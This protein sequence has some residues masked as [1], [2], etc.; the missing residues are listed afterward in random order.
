MNWIGGT[1]SRSRNANAKGS[2]LLKQKNHFA[3]A[4]VKLQNEQR[5]SLPEIQYFDFGEWKPENQIHGEHP[6]GLVKGTTSNQRTLDQF[7]NVQRVVRKLR[8]LRPRKQEKKRKRS[9]INDTE[10]HVLPS[11]IAIPPVSP[12][13]INSRAPSDSPSSRAEPV[14]R[15]SLKRR[16]TSASSTSDELYPLATLDTV[17]AKRCRLLQETDWVGIER[18]RR[19]SKPV[20]MRFTDAKDRDLIGRRRPLNDSAIDNRWDGRNSKPMKIPLMAPGGEE[21]GNWGPDGMSIRIGSTN[22]NKGPISDEIL[23]CGHSTE[24]VRRS[25]HPR[26]KYEYES[27]GRASRP[28]HPTCKVTTPSGLRD[29]SSEPFH[30]LFSPEEVQQSGIAQLVEAA[31]IAE[32]STPPLLEDELQLPGDYHLPE[33][34]PGFRLV[35][36]RTPQPPGQISDPNNGSTPIIR[37][38]AYIERQ[39]PGT[40]TK[41]TARPEDRNVHQDEIPGYATVEAA[42]PSTSPLSVATSRYM[43]ELERQSFNSDAPRLFAPTPADKAAPSRAQPASKKN[44]AEEKQETTSVQEPKISMQPENAHSMAHLEPPED[45]NQYEDESW[46]NFVNLDDIRDSYENQQEPTRAQTPH[47]TTASAPPYEEKVPNQSPRPPSARKTPSPPLDD[48][49]IWQ[50]FIFSSPNPKNQWILEDASPNPPPAKHTTSHKLSPTQPSMVAEASTSPWKQNPHLT[51]SMLSDSPSSPGSSSRQ[52]QPST[53]SPRD[54]DST[55]PP[56]NPPYFSPSQS[57]PHPS[58]LTTTPPSTHQPSPNPPPQNPSNPSSLLAHASSSTDSPA[59]TPSRLPNPAPQR[60]KVI[61]KTPSRYV[62]SREPAAV[63]LGKAVGKSKGKGKGKGNQTRS[64]AEAVERAEQVVS[65]KGRRKSQARRD[66]DDG[67]VTDRD[68]IVD[69]WV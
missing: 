48:E 19:M 28:Q 14:T 32:D 36:E 35:F 39:L 41:Q 55:Q 16:R 59:R 22:A 13:I 7:E 68:E 57:P 64:L 46:R 53:S 51:G 3:K 66:D 62:G 67:D 31:T 54:P 1:L 9:L 40:V 21:D 10:G 20:K 8:S 50:A 49:L 45:E 69:D 33:P 6:S 15:R 24:L 5:P 18:Q 2:L 58:L 25:A 4:R 12:T 65:S 38:F 29:G 42:E 17:E 37:D 26:Y 63:H 56:R 47:V 61:F 43:Q 34:E 52:V 27:A 60:E 23:D 44:K 11:G 30:S